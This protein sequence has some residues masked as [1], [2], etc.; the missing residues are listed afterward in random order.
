MEWVNWRGGVVSF[1]GLVYV[2]LCKIDCLIAYGDLTAGHYIIHTAWRLHRDRAA[3][4][5]LR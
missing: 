2:V 1:K 3:F 4:L 5:K